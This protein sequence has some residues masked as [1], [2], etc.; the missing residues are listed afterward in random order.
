MDL[1]ERIAAILAA[2][3][4]QH[5]SMNQLADMS[6]LS[7]ATVSRTLSGKTEPSIHTLS[8]MEEALG[9]YAP[10]PEEDPIAARLEQDPLLKYYFELQESRILRLRAHYNMLL[11][12]KNRWLKILFTILLL[13]VC[14]AFGAIIFD[15]LHPNIGWYTRVY[16]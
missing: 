11:A 12:E 9:I 3:E 4:K 6:Q 16:P 1:Q 13:L 14:L 2:K 8:A 10:S 15:M 7:T 5:L